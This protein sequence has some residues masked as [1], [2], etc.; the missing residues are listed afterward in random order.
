MD[1][2]F[3][4]GYIRTYWVY[5]VF[6]SL[7]ASIN[8]SCKLFH[9]RNDTSQA[10]VK[11]EKLKHMADEYTI[12]LFNFIRGQKSQVTSNDGGL[13]IIVLRKSLVIVKGPD[14]GARQ[15]G[16]QSWIYHLLLKL[17]NHLYLSFL[18]HKME[19]RIIVFSSLCVM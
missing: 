3:Q 11:Q 7:L 2:H 19:I 1:C 4:R 12:L 13:D 5:D 8:V 6:C 14:F 10:C 15:L 18:F 16:F 17:L 9:K